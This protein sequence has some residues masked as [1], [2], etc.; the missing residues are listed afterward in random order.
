MLRARR[1]SI[2]KFLSRLG[3]RALQQHWGAEPLD[4]TQP[5]EIT[6]VEKSW[7]AASELDCLA[8][9]V[10]GDMRGEQLEEQ[11]WDAER[12]WAGEAWRATGER[13]ADLLYFGRWPSAM[14]HCS[15][16]FSDQSP[17]MPGDLG[18]LLASPQALCK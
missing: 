3:F 11:H 1:A 5:L 7:M 13:A 6:V 12:Q 8:S 4:K 17:A 16:A 14:P 10:N 9:A 18:L 2:D 15:W